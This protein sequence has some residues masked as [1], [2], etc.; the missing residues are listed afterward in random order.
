MKTICPIF[1]LLLLLLSCSQ[2]NIPATPNRDVS[3][4]KLHEGPWM[5]NFKNEVFTRCL[6]KVYPAEL[7]RRIDSTDASS[8]AN[9]EC[10]NYDSQVLQLADSLAT[11]FA[12]RPAAS[13]TIE[14]KR[15]TMNVCLQY[16]NSSELDSIA[17]RFYN[18]VE[19]KN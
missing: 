15:V 4:V 5:T 2:R 14:N 13:W 16:R 1:I 18:R 12:N 8:A 9:K 19:L 7:T 3:L 10:L 17:V 11:A 6:H